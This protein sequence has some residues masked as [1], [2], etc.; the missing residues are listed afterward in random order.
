MQVMP[1]PDIAVYPVTSH[2]LRLR[3]PGNAAYAEQ[4]QE[5]AHNTRTAMTEVDDVVARIGSVLCN[6]KFV[7]DAEGCGS[8]TFARQAELSRHH[9]TLH[10]AN[11]CFDEGWDSV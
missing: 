11:R 10:A 1:L 5:R 3:Y 9:T 4:E 2:L 8:Q 7:Y 6:G